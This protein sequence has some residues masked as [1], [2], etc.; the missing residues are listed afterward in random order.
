MKTVIMTVVLFLSISMTTLFPQEK[1]RR[2]LKEEKKLEKQEQ[3]MAMLNAREFIFIA[4]LAIPSGMRPVNLP[5][6]QN[7]VKFQP[8]LIESYMPFFGYA[9][10]SV[11][12]GSDTGLKFEGKPESFT[13]QKNKNSFQVDAVVN[14]ESDKFT[15]SLSVGLEG[16]AS[17]TIISNKRSAVSYRGEIYEIKHNED[18]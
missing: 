17:L 4:T 14:G 8:E 3:I 10:G 1:S 15:L 12:Y 13:V 16:N 18:L 6:N 7:H 5:V 9:T 2:E 11:G